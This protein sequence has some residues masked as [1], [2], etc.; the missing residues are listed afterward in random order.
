MYSLST[1]QSHTHVGPPPHQT[2]DKNYILTHH[3]VQLCWLV[4]EACIESDEELQST[5]PFTFTGD[6]LTYVWWNASQYSHLY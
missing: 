6:P 4:C 5:Y 2:I 3:I 1:V